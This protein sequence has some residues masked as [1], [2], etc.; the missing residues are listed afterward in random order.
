MLPT[1][2]PIIVGNI[3]AA[4]VGTLTGSLKKQNKGFMTKLI[5]DKSQQ[6]AEIS[7]IYIN[8]AIK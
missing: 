2:P 8:I 1:I 7:V 6:T 5:T 4:A 3:F